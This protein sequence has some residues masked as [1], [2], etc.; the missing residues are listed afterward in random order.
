MPR[1]YAVTGGICLT[2]KKNRARANYANECW[3]CLDLGTH[4]NQSDPL[5]GEMPP[6]DGDE[7][8]VQRRARIVHESAMA[9]NCSRIR[10]AINKQHDGLT[11]KQW[12]E[13]R[14]LE[15]DCEMSRGHDTG[16]RQAAD[17]ARDPFAYT[18]H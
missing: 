18:L 2:C 12:R 4:E 10:A 7:D 13:Q 3:D 11:L 9:E 16:G 14:M 15:A 8:E 17:W 6:E 1:G 5:R